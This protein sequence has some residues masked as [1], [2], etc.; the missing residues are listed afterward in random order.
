MKLIAFAI[1]L[2]LS[3]TATA[4]EAKKHKRWKP[5]IQK[6]SFYSK[7]QPTASGEWFNPSKLT[8]AHKTL[9]FGTQ[10]KVTNLRNGKSVVVRINDRGPRRYG[11]VIDVS[12]AAARELG[13]VK[14]GIVPVKIERLTAVAKAPVPVPPAPSL[15]PPTE[16][17]APTATVL[18]TIAGFIQSLFKVA[19]HANLSKT[20]V[21]LRTF[22]NRVQDTC[23][24]VTVISGFRPGARVAGSGRVSLHAS[25]KAVDYQIKDTVCALKVAKGW[26]G[27]H[28]TDYSRVNH[29]HISWAP[30]SGEWKRRFVHGS[31]K[32]R[33]AKRWR[34]RF[35]ARHH[36]RW[37]G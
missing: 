26:P 37:R 23:G 10:V 28:S 1:A 33:Y 4:A 20:P 25:G 31:S 11:R 9:P 13:M 34:Y 27:G 8:A 18:P 2:A 19:N 3:L 21:E 30:G 12:L 22:L 7:P 14:A 5:A 24:T 36:R 6:A 17:T 29:F 32:V 16:T 15:P 35:A